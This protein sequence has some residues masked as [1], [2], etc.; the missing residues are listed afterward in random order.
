MNGS[1]I[2]VLVAIIVVIVIAVGAQRR[3]KMNP[4]RAWARGRP[5]GDAT[6][7]LGLRVAES[8]PADRYGQRA[9]A[10]TK[11]ADPRTV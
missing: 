4:H 7:R 6:W 1:E 8:A 3:R 2:A 10:D 5:S 11:T 9:G